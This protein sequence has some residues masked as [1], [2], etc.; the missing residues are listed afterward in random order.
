MSEV[1]SVDGV[2]LGPPGP[3]GI[4]S[5]M[6]SELWFFKQDWRKSAY[7]HQAI[8]PSQEEARAHMSLNKGLG[9][10]PSKIEA[11][12]CRT[13]FA[14]KSKQQIGMNGTCL[15]QVTQSTFRYPA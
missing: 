12:E 9:V 8:K 14:V 10:R 11:G 13:L 5:V 1:G 15:H 3:C 6:S 7:I 4:D 2:S